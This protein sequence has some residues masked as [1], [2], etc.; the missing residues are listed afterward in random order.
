MSGTILNTGHSVIFTVDNA[1]RHHVNVSGGPLS[2]KYQFEE[3]HLHYG[4]D[5]LA[6][7]EHSINGHTFPAEVST[8]TYI[9]YLDMISWFYLC[10]NQAEAVLQIPF[11]Y[12]KNFVSR[13]LDGVSGALDPSIL[14][15]S[16]LDSL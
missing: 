16:K 10:W 14:K 5:D 4:L 13:H 9:L 12:T 2:Y 6:G 3:I 7:S 1:T 15:E 11:K 8:Q